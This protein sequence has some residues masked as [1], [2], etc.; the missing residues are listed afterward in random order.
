MADALH[1]HTLGLNTR[2]RMGCW[3]VQRTITTG[4][5]TIAG[6]QRPS[7]RAIC[8]LCFSVSARER[9]FE[10]GTDVSLPFL[11]PGTQG[12]PSRR[13]PLERSDDLQAQ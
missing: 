8:H 13:V 11:W 3:P 10:H 4:R 2:E 6:G 12:P 1:G 9:L 7:F 5:A